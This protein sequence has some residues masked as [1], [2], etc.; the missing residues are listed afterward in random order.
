MWNTTIINHANLL[1]TALAH[2][3]EAHTCPY[4]GAVPGQ[5]CKPKN[6]RYARTLSP[7]KRRMELVDES[8]PVARRL[9]DY[10]DVM[11]K[12]DYCQYMN[13]EQ[14]LGILVELIQLEY[15]SE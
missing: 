3:P 2:T 15:Q 9:F 10:L 5:M 6:S 13:L 1:G 12:Q 8:L 7:H 11:A 4:C 14:L